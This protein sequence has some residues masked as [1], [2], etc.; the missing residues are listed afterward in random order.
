VTDKPAFF[1]IN[2]LALIGV[3]M[4]GG[5]LIRALQEKS[6]V[7]RVIGIDV[8]S[9]TLHKA[10]QLGI[11]DEITTLEAFVAA[12][13]RVDLIVIAT[14]VGAMQPIFSTL[15]QHADIA[16]TLITD[17]GSTKQSAIEDATEGFGHLPK[18]FVPSHPIAGREHIGITYADANMFTGH[19]VIITPHVNNSDDTINKIENLWQA[20]G[21]TVNR[22]PAEY[23]D[24]ILA[25]TSHLPHVLA[26]G[27]MDSLSNTEEGE[28]IFDY[29]AGGFTAFTR[30]ASSNPIMWRDICLKNRN[31]ILYW[32]DQYQNTLSA[33][34]DLIANNDVKDMLALF[35]HSKLTRDQYLQKQ[36]P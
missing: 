6:L 1:P 11:I 34:R 15:S 36:Q 18:N 22:L 33:L 5:S 27:L 2:R 20:T 13:W 14:P 19:R 10:K 16:Q 21:A 12:N 32:L 35:S 31:N 25:A 24:R 23:H 4:I 17:V 26:Y 7:D 29:A 30:T 9:E 8:D 3:G 28:A